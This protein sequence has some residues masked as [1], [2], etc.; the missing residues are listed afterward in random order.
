MIDYDSIDNWFPSLTDALA[1]VVTETSRAKIAASV[2]QY[3]EDAKALLFALHPQ[4]S[5]VDKTLVWLKVN[6]LAAYHGT[7]LTDEEVASIRTI[8]LIPLAADGR[9][10]RLVRVLSKHPNWTAVAN[11]LDAELQKHGNGD[12]A[13]H[14]EGQVHLTLSRS[15]LECSFNHYLLYGSEFDQHV[16][17]SLLGKDGKALLQQDGE[18]RVIQVELDGQLALDGAHAHFTVEDVIQR[19]EIPNLVNEFLEAWA[20]RLAVP[21]YQPKHSR[22]DCGIWF[23]RSIPSTSIKSVETYAPPNHDA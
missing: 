4:A 14:R 19:G 17:T 3:V 20:Y 9:R 16:A 12:Q 21:I 1:Q 10:A 6:T 5:L 7:R 8:G 13:G 18:S 22:T 23:R 15:G 11:R 2:P